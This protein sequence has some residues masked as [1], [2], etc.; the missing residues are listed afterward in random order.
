MDLGGERDEVDADSEF[1]G[2]RWSDYV[3]AAL[4]AM[5]RR[6]GHAGGRRGANSKERDSNGGGWPGQQFG[7]ACGH[8]QVV[9]CLAWR[10]ADPGGELAELAFE[11]EN[12]ELGIPCGRLDQY[13]SAFG[14]D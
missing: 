12:A 1:T 3:I 10:R 6:G 11:A 2:G 5:R 9:R 13:A 7:L 14:G 4:R 8:N